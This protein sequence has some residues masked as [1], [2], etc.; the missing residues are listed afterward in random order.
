M[1][2]FD[3][4]TGSRIVAVIPKREVPPVPVHP[5]AV[6]HIEVV[7]S[8]VIDGGKHGRMTQQSAVETRRSASLRARDD[9]RWHESKRSCRL[10]RSAYRPVD[11]TASQL[12]GFV[13]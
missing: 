7:D 9:K 8:F 3:S 10:V 12:R 5:L 4:A 1:G 6:V 2:P 11:R 13:A